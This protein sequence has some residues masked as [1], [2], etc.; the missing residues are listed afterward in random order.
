[1]C[2]D[3][4]DGDHPMVLGKYGDGG[5]VDNDKVIGPANRY[6]GRSTMVMYCQ[7]CHN[8]IPKITALTITEAISIIPETSCA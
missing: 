4:G 7:P 5:D 6:L 1:M 2:G 8:K 3:T